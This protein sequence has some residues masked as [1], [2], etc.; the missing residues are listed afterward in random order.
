MALVT[1]S[2][3]Y[4]TVFIALILLISKGWTVS[5]NNLS[6]N[7]LSSITLLMGAV[8]LTYSAYYVS[9]NIPGMKIFIGFILNLL[10]LILLIVVVKNILETRQCLR[11]ML[12]IVRNSDVR[13]MMEAVSLKIKI[14]NQFFVV[15]SFYFLYE[16][17][18]NGIA[19]S[20]EQN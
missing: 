7:D 1:I 15:A 16:L 8:Y 10:Y 9:I 20:I 12:T 2:T 14:I 17:I 5:R 4:Q 6:R 13:Q 18:L 3:I 19:P 11:Q